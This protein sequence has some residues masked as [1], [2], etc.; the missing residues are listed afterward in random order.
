MEI[1]YVPKETIY[2]SFGCYNFRSERISIRSDLPRSAQNFVKE[3]EMN[4][5]RDGPNEITA[6]LKAAWRYPWGFIVVAI[7]SLAPYR[8]AFY[9]K[10]LREWR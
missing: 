10:R 1:K 6:N 5:H 8:L 3:H 9:W 2:P 7:M 4:H